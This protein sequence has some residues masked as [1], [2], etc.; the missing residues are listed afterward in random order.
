VHSLEVLLG[1]PWQDSPF[2][3]QLSHAPFGTAELSLAFH[4]EVSYIWN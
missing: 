2:A 3:K 4:P 1:T